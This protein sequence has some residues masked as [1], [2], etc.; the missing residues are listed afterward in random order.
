MM[1]VRSIKR[2]IQRH[3]KLIFFTIVAAASA[4]TH[5]YDGSARCCA[6]VPAPVP[7]EIMRANFVVPAVQRPQP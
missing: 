6:D 4:I 5:P 3:P 2:F 1:A 7:E